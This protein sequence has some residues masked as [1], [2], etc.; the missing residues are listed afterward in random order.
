MTPARAYRLVRS[1]IESGALVRPKSCDVCGD[2]P[3]PASDGRS[4]IHAHHHDYA[5]P[6]EVEWLCAKCHRK[7]TPLPAVMGAPV[8]GVKN[9]AAK[10]GPEAVKEILS[11]DGKTQILARKY[12]VHISTVSRVRRGETWKLAAAERKGES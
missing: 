4:R 3:P 11:T 1:A 6:L 10:L 8:H 7:E 12:R 2:C 9:G 5:K